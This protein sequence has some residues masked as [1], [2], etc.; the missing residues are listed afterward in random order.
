[1]QFGLS[2]ADIFGLIAGTAGA[3]LTLVLIHA[4]YHK[5][6]WL[7]GFVATFSYALLSG[8]WRSMQLPHE[9]VWLTNVMGALSFLSLPFLY[10]YV[11]E[12]L[13]RTV[14]GKW[15]HFV[16][17]S[18]AA[19]VIAVWPDINRLY[20]HSLLLLQGVMYLVVLLR[21]ILAFRRQVQQQYSNLTNIDVPWLQWMI[22]A[23]LL[24]ALFDSLAFPLLRYVGFSV[25]FWAGSV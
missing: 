17:A 1:M 18:V 20:L 13:G 5:T 19:G 16:P 2:L 8:I 22:A 25:S 4:R 10:F 9:A 11:C 12:A 21:L 14:L 3:M 24:L 7:A 23:L 15:L 6:L